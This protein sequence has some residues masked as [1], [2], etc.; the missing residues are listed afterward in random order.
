MLAYQHTE[1]ARTEST[2][3]SRRSIDEEEPIKSPERQ[4]EPTSEST[5]PSAELV[6]QLV[7]R[8]VSQGVAVKLAKG[9]PANIELQCAV[10]DWRVKTK[11]KMDI[12]G[13]YLKGMVERSDPPPE[14]YV[15]STRTTQAKQQEHH[16]EQQAAQDKAR[17]RMIDKKIM[18][19]WQSLSEQQKTDTDALAVASLAPEARTVLD[20]MPKALKTLAIAEPR[21]EYIERQILR[22]N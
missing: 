10:F 8:G 14:G 7:K 20:S 21:W 18:D 13:A 2:A 15:K 6:G 9:D 12:P 4:Q 22:L 16:Q 5:A 19:Y 1:P 17:R 11:H 3:K